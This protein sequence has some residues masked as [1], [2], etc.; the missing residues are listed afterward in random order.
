MKYKGKEHYQTHSVKPA[1]HSFQN[2]ARTQ[3]NKENYR[4]IFIMNIDSKILN[5]I[6]AI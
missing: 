3:G 6:L 4:P 1:L 5:K 2:Q